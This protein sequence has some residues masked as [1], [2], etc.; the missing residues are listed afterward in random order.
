MFRPIAPTADPPAAAP[1]G[2]YY[3]A[4]VDRAHKW[5]KKRTLAA[6]DIG[7]PPKPA[8]MRNRR[9]GDKDFRYFCRH[10][11]PASFPLAWSADHL[12][13][14]ATIHR[15]TTD[16]GLYAFAM[17]RGSGKTTLC[18]RAAIWAILSG[19]HQFVTLIA[20]DLGKAQKLL[21]AIKSEITQNELLLADYPAEVWSFH[22]L[23]N[24]AR[25]ASG[26]RCE[27]R[28]TFVGWKAEEIVFGQVAGSAAAGSIIRVAGLTAALRGM[29]HTLPGGRSVRPSLAIIDDPQTR[30][31]AASPSQCNT[32]EATISGDILG[33]AGPGAKIAALLPCTVIYQHD[34]A[35]R[36]LDQ[37]L[38]PDWQGKRSK[39]IYAWPTDTALWDEY[40][41]IRADSLR[42]GLGISQ[43]TAFYKKNRKKMDAGGKAAWPARKNPDELSAIQ[44]GMNLKIR[45]PATFA[46]EYQ[47]EPLD[48]A[49]P[50]VVIPTAADLET[51]QRPHPRGALPPDATYRTAFID[52]Q[53]TLLFFL[54]MTWQQNFTGHIHNYGTYPDQKKTYYTLAAARHTIFTAK[55][56]AGFEGAMYAALHALCEQ[57]ETG[58]AM[59]LDRGFIDGQYADAA[60]I[61]YRVCAERPGRVWMPSH[62]RG[63]GAKSR[64]FDMYKRKPGDAIG[65]NWR[66]PRPAGTA[67]RQ[68]YV[69][70]ETNHYKTL[71]AERLRT[72]VGDPGAVTFFKSRGHR[73][74]FDNLAAEYAVQVTANGRTVLEWQPRP[75]SP[76]NHLFDCYVGNCLA[77]SVLGCAPAGIETGPEDRKRKRVKLSALAAKKQ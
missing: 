49:K 70:Y 46:A 67:R 12:D 32:R 24:E 30:E 17:P 15:A 20:A 3:R 43:A 65:P 10:Y 56:G 29:K 47:N 75:G 2:D 63:Q 74:L 19:R 13:A 53:K 16:G 23:D 18:E 76:D 68:S 28:K 37:Q 77:A 38:H 62:G 73:V 72:A 58:H 6:Q 59:P 60:D 22:G 54:E 1:P 69:T 14:L 11:F 27:G 21:A 50:D 33:M 34:M 35:D 71:A 52:T 57:I 5:I 26:Q 45:D 7:P 44:H 40:E 42:A 66:I 61:V 55:D 51:R 41:Q 25:R 4:N 48:D 31:S 36:L 8:N 9:R 39:L 64:P